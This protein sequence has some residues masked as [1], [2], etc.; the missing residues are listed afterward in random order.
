MFAT[1][2]RGPAT[3][4]TT[5]SKRQ[6]HPNIYATPSSDVFDSPS[7]PGVPSSSPRKGSPHP[8][9]C[10][11]DEG[12]TSQ[13]AMGRDAPA[14]KLLFPD[15]PF[16]GAETFGEGSDF[17]SATQCACSDD[18]GTQYNMASQPVAATADVT[19]RPEQTALPPALPPAPRTAASAA[20]DE[21]LGRLHDLDAT[22]RD[23]ERMM[24]LHRLAGRSGPACND[25][26][27]YLQRC[28]TISAP[29]RA[30]WADSWA[31]AGAGAGAAGQLLIHARGCCER[32]HVARGRVRP[33][34]AVVVAGAVVQG[35]GE[36]WSAALEAI[37]EAV[38]G[39]QLA[40][41]SAAAAPVWLL[42]ACLPACWMGQDV[43]AADEISLGFRE[44]GR[45][46]RGRG[47]GWASNAAL[48]A[49]PCDLP[50]LSSVMPLCRR[51]QLLIAFDTVD[52]DDALL[53]DTLRRYL[54]LRSALQLKLD[55]YAGAIQ[56][57]S[58]AL[59][60]DPGSFTAHYRRGV[61]RYAQLVA[62]PPPAMGCGEAMYGEAMS[63]FRLAAALAPEGHPAH[64]A[65]ELFLREDNEDDVADEEEEEDSEDGYLQVWPGDCGEGSWRGHYDA[66]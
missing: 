49:A 1:P 2:I 29:G 38:S 12:E 26:S 27:T 51:S 25:D 64:R 28:A 6:Q 11:S 23:L 15:S 16:K 56:S 37:D 59:R 61:A 63:D 66:I 60:V 34:R 5:P 45:A 35:E 24:A 13:A 14:S 54:L 8:Q 41:L 55:N 7:L 9:S 36:D 17:G 57:T 48:Y 40:A 22:T 4:N 53:S 21:L 10:L 47:G 32:S 52:G 31:G 20:V 62:P 58:A 18:G 33:G 19:C 43:V 46:R 30:S 44:W 50:L 42:S 3:P 39:Q 65:L